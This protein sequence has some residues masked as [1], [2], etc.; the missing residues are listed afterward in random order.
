[1]MVKI[2]KKPLNLLKKPKRDKLD[3]KVA[4]KLHFFKRF[5]ERVCYKLTEQKYLEIKNTTRNSG[6]K[7]RNG[8]GLNSIWSVRI[9][10][11]TYTIVYNA[12]KDYLVTIW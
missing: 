12:F 7:I 9:D 3:L 2:I 6:I 1:M 5:E 11:Y 10:G 4:R 8:D